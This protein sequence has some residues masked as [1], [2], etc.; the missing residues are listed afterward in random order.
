MNSTTCILHPI[1]SAVL[2]ECLLLI[3]PLI[4]NIINTTFVTGSVPRALKVAAITPVL[5]KPGCD[6]SDLSNYKPVS[7]L[8]FLA[9]VLEC[10]VV[11]QLHSHLS[12]NKLLEIFQSGFRLGHST[13]T[14]LVQVMNDFLVSVY[15]GA[16]TILVLLDLSA[17]FDTVC[18]SILIERLETWL[19]ISGTVLEWFKSYLSDRSQF[20]VLGN[21]KSNVRQVCRGVPQSSVLGPILFSIYM[22]P[23]GQI[24]RKHGLGFRFYADDSQIYISMKTN[25][26]GISETLTDCLQEIKIWM[27]HNFLK[28]NGTK[29]EVI[30]VGPPQLLPRVEILVCILITVYYFP[31]LKFIIMVFFLILT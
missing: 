24:I 16:L 6:V 27:Y 19:G 4:L 7:N 5:K 30:L 8:P 29:S 15:S 25:I 13:E 2:K 28:L 1:P 17:A 12:L 26:T 10:V 3:S 20:V 14:A 31:P 18:H 9:K 11:S 23:L 22:L 21:N